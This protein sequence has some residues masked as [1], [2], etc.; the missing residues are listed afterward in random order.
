MAEKTPNFVQF[1]AV[2]ILRGAGRRNLI[3]LLVLLN[4]SNF[5]SP[6]KHFVSIADG[7]LGK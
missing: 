4:Y 5:R 2:K 7:F 1:L 3:G 6:Y